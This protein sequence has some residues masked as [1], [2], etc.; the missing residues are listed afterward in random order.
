M[1]SKQDGG[2]DE[3]VFHSIMVAE[4]ERHIEYKVCAQ[5]TRNVRYLHKDQEAVSGIGQ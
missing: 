5:H 1:W 4:M 2:L 3:H